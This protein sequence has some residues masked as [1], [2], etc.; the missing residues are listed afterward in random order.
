MEQLEDSTLNLI[1]RR[2]VRSNLPAYVIIVLIIGAF[3]SLPLV[4]VDVVTSVKGMVRPLQEPAEIFSPISGIVD[5]SVLMENRRFTARDTLVWIK[6]DLLKA[7]IDANQA[8][9]EIHRESVAD[10]GLILDN[11]IPLHTSHYIQSYRN[12]Q[13]ARA[14]LEIQKEFLLGEH[15]TAETLFGQQVISRHEYEKALSQYRDICARE[16]DLCE[17]YKSNLEGDLL[18]INLEIGRISDEVIITL[19]TLDEYCLVAPVTGTIYNSRSLSA[20]SVVHPGMSLAMISPSGSLVA[21]CYIDPRQIPLVKEGTRVKLRFDDSGFRSH[22][23]QETEVDLL[24][25]EVTLINGTPAYRIR[26]TLDDA[27]IHYTNGTSEAV[28]IGMTFTASFILFRC[29]V[30]TLILEK[31]NLWVN[32]TVSTQN[33]ETGS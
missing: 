30:A 18:R 11:Q 9:I 27:Q 7:R 10:I 13:A 20:G 16:T 4:K 1:Y 33:H 14:R 22:H 19:T 23:P 8:R 17:A 29:S 15:K 12:H 6:A 21:E 3:S 31:A 5:R 32:P 28:R 25:Q 26:C 2:Q 24:D